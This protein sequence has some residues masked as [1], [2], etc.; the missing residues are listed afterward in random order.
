MTVDRPEP[1]R[2]S[3]L[4]VSHA[5]REEVVER[6]KKAAADGR[7]DLD[8]LDE[9][10]DRA[11]TAKTYGDLE[12]LTADL[13]PEAPPA[14]EKPLVLKGGL[15]GATRTGRWQVPARMTAYGGMGGVRLDFSQA[16]CHLP[17]VELEVHGQTGGVKVIVP[18]GWAVDSSEVD[19]DLGGMKD[20]TTPDRLPGTPLIHVTGTGGLGG[21]IIRH[22]NAWER[23]KL[24]QAHSS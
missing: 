19:P 15:Q 4:R 6:L 2:S 5:E 3:E 21:V 1:L 13:P 8:E 11:L 20:K 23:R 22:P 18:D 12:P 9:R 17:R 10:L 7:I 24:R 16:E 14:P